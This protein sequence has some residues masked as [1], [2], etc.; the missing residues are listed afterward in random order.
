MGRR[1]VASRRRRKALAEQRLATAAEL[2][3]GVAVVGELLDV[4]A[5][6]GGAREGVGPTAF[7][8]ALVLAD[9]IRRG[10]VADRHVHY[11]AQAVAKLVEVGRLEAGEAT[12]H[13]LSVAASPADFEKYVRE[14]RA[15]IEKEQH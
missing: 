4:A 1:S 3:N 5:L 9:R 8:G 13:S 10:Q 2:V 14:L 15:Q 7:A 12:S 6:L 11:A